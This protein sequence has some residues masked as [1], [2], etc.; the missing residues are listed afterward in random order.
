MKK[1]K[2]HWPIPAALLGAAGVIGLVT[3]SLGMFP[4]F[5][6]FNSTVSPPSPLQATSG[7]LTVAL[8]NGSAGSFTASVSDMA[9][10][11][12]VERYVDLSNSGTVGVSAVNLSAA[13]S[14]VTP[15]GSPLFAGDTAS[16]GLQVFGQVCPSGSSWQESGTPT[17]YTCSGGVTPTA[18][19]GTPVSL[20]SLTATGSTLTP[21][22]GSVAFIAPASGSPNADTTNL[23]QTNGVIVNLPS[24]KNANG[25][26]EVL[27]TTTSTSSQDILI[28]AYLPPEADNA[29]QGGA[30][31]VTYTFTAVQRAGEA[32]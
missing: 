20:A 3:G 30:G 15:S 7:T 5:S 17:L 31:N 4:G 22:S 23:S 19:F 24:V 12:Y 32:K 10:G 28:T 27:G 2:R 13:V 1:L 18:I 6:A 8:A 14:S 9:P 25:V 29:F 16:A 11:D 21:P 26:P